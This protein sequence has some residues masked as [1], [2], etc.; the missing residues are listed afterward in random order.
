MHCAACFARHCPALCTVHF[1]RPAKLSHSTCPVRCRTSG[2]SRR[3]VLAQRW[4]ASSTRSIIRGYQP[5]AEWTWTLCCADCPGNTPGKQHCAAKVKHINATIYTCIFLLLF[6]TLLLA[7]DFNKCYTVIPRNRLILHC[8]V[9]TP[10]LSLHSLNTSIY[11][12]T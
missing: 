9:L 3:G 4:R 12:Y 1:A 8:Q 10:S 6:I 11:W 5:C 2:I 7:E